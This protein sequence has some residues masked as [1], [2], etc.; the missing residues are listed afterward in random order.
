MIRKLFARDWIVT[1]MNG[2]LKVTS[3]GR[4]TRD[5]KEAKRF[6]AWGGKRYVRRYR[7]RGLSLMLRRY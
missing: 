4:Y 7:K 2:D 5:A 1:N 6:T 3:D